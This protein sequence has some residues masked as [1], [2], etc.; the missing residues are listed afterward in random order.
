[1]TDNN[2]EV[3]NPITLKSGEMFFSKI[4]SDS[5]ELTIQIPKDVVEFNKET[6]KARIQIEDVKI[7][8]FIM[9]L[10]NDVIKKT[11]ENSETWFGK[12]IS[13]E[14]CSQ[15]YRES[16]K[17]NF[18]TC[19][20]D[21]DTYFYTSGGDLTLDEINDSEKGISLIKCTGIIFTKTSFFIKWDLCQ[22]KIKRDKKKS[23]TINEYIIRDLKEDDEILL[24]D[25]VIE[26]L[27][28]VTLF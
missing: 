24:D 3:F 6:K 5:T 9:G 1:M 13:A 14:D 4:M 18:L 20:F 17:E 2:L 16:L 10:S 27:K 28:N 19:F 22:F 21:D 26:K 15:I 7:K 23:E 25:E 12:N 8:D 11:S